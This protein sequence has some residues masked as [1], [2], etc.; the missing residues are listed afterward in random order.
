MSDAVL[1]W[2]SVGLIVLLGA[3]LVTRTVLV[4]R[5]AGT[6]TAESVRYH[7][8]RL[9][10]RLDL[11]LLVGAALLVAAGILRIVLGTLG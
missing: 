6:G 7:R 11:G 1:V 10:R 5:T 9:V 8:P 4:E 3:A 2:L